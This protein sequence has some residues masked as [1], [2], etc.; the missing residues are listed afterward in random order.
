MSSSMP[1]V[2]GTL[3]VETAAFAPALRD[4]RLYLFPL[5]YLP[6]VAQ[7]NFPH[8]RLA[9][10]FLITHHDTR[11]QSW[12][13]SN[14]CSLNGVM[15]EKTTDAIC[16]EPNKPFPY[17]LQVPHYTCTDAQLQNRIS[18]LDKRKKKCKRIAL[19]QSFVPPVEEE[20]RSETDHHSAT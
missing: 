2:Y 14:S 3:G 13:G 10:L 6:L 20:C 15:M 17:F 19:G 9:R 4:P 18:E 8:Q 5:L 11:F 1:G 7:L 16:L 12:P